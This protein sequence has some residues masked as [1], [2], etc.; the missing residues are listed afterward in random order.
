[1]TQTAVK[2]ACHTFTAIIIIIIIIIINSASS[3]SS[4]CNVTAFKYRTANYQEYTASAL[5]K[6]RSLV[7]QALVPQQ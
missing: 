5:L 1:M 2:R 4:N 6:H 3:S 7:S